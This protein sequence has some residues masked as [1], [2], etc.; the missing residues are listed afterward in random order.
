ML[1]LTKSELQSWEG[2]GKGYTIVEIQKASSA[3]CIKKGQI[4]QIR[5]N[6]MEPIAL[7]HE[8]KAN[9]HM[10]HFDMLATCCDFSS[11]NAS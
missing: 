9:M 10:P 11:S 7:E 4:G 2:K 8:T 3:S 6:I 1:H 5:I